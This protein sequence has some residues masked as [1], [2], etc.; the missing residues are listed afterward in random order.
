M[1]RA[2]HVAAFIGLEKRQGSVEHAAVF[3]GLYKVG[4]HRPLTYEQFWKIPAY[5]KLK[6]FGLAG[7]V[8]GERPHVLWFDL[9]ITDFYKKWRGKLVIEWPRPPIKWSRFADRATFPI[10]AVVEDSLLHEAMPDWRDCIWSWAELSTLPS[11]WRET[12]RQWRG[13]Y[14]IFDQ[15]DGKGY[16]GAAYGEDNILGRWEHY[17]ASGHGGNVRLRK[18]SPENFTFSILER[19]SPDMDSDD[20]IDLERKWKDRLHTRAPFGLNDN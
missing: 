7:F 2:K 11:K 3:V 19:V 8:E 15:S 17:E 5:Q 20:V 12:L 1:L 13:I 4:N 18:R 9:T 6:R 10:C 16:V 14:Y